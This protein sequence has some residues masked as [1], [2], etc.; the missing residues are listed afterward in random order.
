MSNVKAYFVSKDR[1][2]NLTPNF[3][4]KEF[5]SHDGADKVL[6]DYELLCLLQL[7]R[8]TINKPLI[9]N[10]GYRTKEHN[11]KV[12]GASNSY[13][14]Y[15]RAFD[16]SG[17]SSSVLANYC[18]TLNINGI[19][20]YSTWVHMDTRDNV[21]HADYTNKGYKFIK[22][23][24]PYLN[25]LSLLGSNNYIVGCIQ[26]MLNTKGYGAGLVDGIFGYNTLRAV[27]DFQ[28][29]NGLKVDG[30]VGKNTWDKLFNI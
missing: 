21:Y 22:V 19:I 24:I 23:S 6:I 1:N 7:I 8:R 13:H 26:H 14:M 15:G 27:K 3:K 9:I 16:V 10:S 29:K 11:R 12:G 5:Q 2:K 18:Y 17:I 30:I 4:V 25:T 28:D 20:I